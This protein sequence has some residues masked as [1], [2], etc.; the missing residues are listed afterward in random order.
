MMS[1]S[2]SQLVSQVIQNAIRDEV[3]A[4]S[5]YH[6]PDASGYLKLDAMEKIRIA[7][8]LSC[9]KHS[10]SGCAGRSES[11]SSPQVTAR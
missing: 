3:Q 6:V 4:L 5:A 2:N 11:L 7:Y 9:S 1:T 8:R 10:H